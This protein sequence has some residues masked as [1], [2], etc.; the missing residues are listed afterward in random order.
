M[1][2]N[3]YSIEQFLP[4]ID[5]LIK[6]HEKR[7]FKQLRAETKSNC[8]ILRFIFIDPQNYN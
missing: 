3:Q 5:V 7:R 1:I 6:K 4:Y 8:K 2:R